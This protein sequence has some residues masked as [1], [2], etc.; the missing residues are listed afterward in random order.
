MQQLQSDHRQMHVA[1]VSLMP[2][3]K[4][5]LLAFL[6]LRIEQLLTSK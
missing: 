5:P 4:L 2:D 1:T 3:F 6:A